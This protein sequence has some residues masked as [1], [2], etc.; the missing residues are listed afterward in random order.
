GRARPKEG[1]HTR[2]AGHWRPTDDLH[3]LVYGP[4]LAWSPEQALRMARA[5][6]RHGVE[7]LEQ[8]VPPGDP[9]AL[10]C[11]RERAPLPVYADLGLMGDPGTGMSV[12]RGLIGL[13]TAPDSAPSR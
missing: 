6:H 8:P 13:P 3:V 7:L 12:D 1:T 10:R 2:E 11:V 4:S 9:D 5:L